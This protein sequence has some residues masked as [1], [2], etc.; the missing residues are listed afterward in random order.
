MF[1]LMV[2]ACLADAP[3]I[4]REVLLPAADAAEQTAC[5]QR[6]DAVAR[7]W[8]ARHADLTLGAV[9]CRP[10][11]RL[12]ALPVTELTRGV[13]VAQGA[14]EQLSAANGGRIANL[15][16]VIADTV[17]VIDT[18]TTRAEA[19]ALYGAIRRITDRPI[20]PVI[21]THM[22]PD[23]IMGAELFSEAGGRIIADSRLPD[24]VARRADTWM[25]TVPRQIGR[26]AFLGTRIVAPDQTIDRATDL[27]LGATVLTLTPQ[28]S[29]HTDSDLTVF[30]ARSA[31]LF[32][33]DL[34]FRGLTPV[35]DGS[36]SGWLA[37]LGA[38]PPMPQP[39]WIVP[40][41]GAPSKSWADATGP[42]TRYL[43]EL[44][45]AV[46]R[47]LTDGMALSQAIPA[48]VT[49]MAPDGPGWADFAPTT[50]RNAATA[51]SQMEWD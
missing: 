7:D 42:E 40:G 16:F 48:I 47:A 29:A 44:R 25:Q 34:I 20:G 9:E 21:L 37:W 17:A 27:A 22:H 31:T 49:M 4:C 8:I 11:E 6:G 19:E 18:G 3:E 35:I 38:G 10:T 23:H 2:M 50:A 39:R 24:A 13:Y 15:S 12:P 14:P 45:A 1:H 26:E 33:G 36:L 43:T 32:T 5:A 46:G 41:H 28:P 51:F 30:D